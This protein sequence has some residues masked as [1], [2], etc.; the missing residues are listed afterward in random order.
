MVRRAQKLIERNLQLAAKRLFRNDEVAQVE[1]VRKAISHLS[2]SWNIAEAVRNADLI[3]E[4][5]TE[6]LQAKQALFVEIE[7]VYKK[8]Y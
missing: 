6:N 5:I 2:Y 7:K 4:A 1:F 3:I 8:Q